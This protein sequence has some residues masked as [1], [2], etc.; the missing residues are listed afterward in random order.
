MAWK[1]VPLLFQ[2]LDLEFTRSR[3]A[4]GQH[5]NRTSS[6]AMLRWNLAQTKIFPEEQ[7]QRLLSKLSSQLV[8]DGEILIRSEESRDAQ[9]NKKKCLE[10]LERMIERAFYE[11]P[12]RKKTKPTRSSQIKRKDSKRHRGEIK[13]GRGKVDWD[14]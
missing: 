8:G 4:G 1:W 11:A 6:A 12:P 13:K 5:V 7:K 2:E 9:M 3:G 14:G 10:K